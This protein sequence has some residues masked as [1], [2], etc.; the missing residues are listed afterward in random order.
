MI[1]EYGKSFDHLVLLDFAGG[2]RRLLCFGRH[3]YKGKLLLR[4]EGVILVAAAC[5][6][7]DLPL[8]SLSRD[9]SPTLDSATGCLAAL[10]ITFSFFF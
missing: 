5:I 10:A 4:D 3:S 8:P 1:Y 6:V 2:A 7:N 9:L